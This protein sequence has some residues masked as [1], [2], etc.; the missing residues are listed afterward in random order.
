M[1]AANAF[2]TPASGWFTA[3]PGADRPDYGS[4]GYETTATQIRAE[5]A[6]NCAVWLIDR[7][8]GATHRVNG[9]PFVVFTRRPDLAIAE[10][11]EG[12]DPAVWDTRVETVGW[13]GAK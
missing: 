8:T 2:G 3:K 12:R 4:T 1:I 6:R 10:M 11:M 7:R 13:E 5:T 9:R